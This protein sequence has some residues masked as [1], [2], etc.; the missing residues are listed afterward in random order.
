MRL[1]AL[2]VRGFKS[3]ADAAL[4]PLD[5]SLIGVVGPNGSGKSNIAD[6]LRWILGEQK[7]RLLRAEKSE[8]LIFNGS[9]QRR[10]LPFAEVS[11]EV[12]GFS[13][14]LPRLTFLRRIHRSGESEYFLN[15]APVRLKDFLAHFWEIGLSPQSIL[16]GGQVE[17]LIHDRG[18][19]RRA[20]IESLAG[21]ER[22][23]FQ[24]KEA[25]VQLERTTQALEQLERV[26]AELKGQ[27]GRLRSQAEKVRQY[28]QLRER[29]QQ[30]LSQ[31]I[32]WQVAQIEKQA[33]RLRGQR[34]ELQQQWERLEQEIRGL[35]LRIQA[36][37]E[38][39][40]T[41]ELTQ[42][43]AALH[44]LRQGLHGVDKE[45]GLLQERLVHLQKEA[46]E[47]EEERAYRVR[48]AEELLQEEQRLRE[49]IE[50][51][52]Q[53]HFRAQEALHSLHPAQQSLS[54]SI[55]QAEKC[56]HELRTRFQEVEK[57]KLTMQ[58]RLHSLQASIQSVRE[59]EAEIDAAI[60]S[61]Q[62]REASWQEERTT[63]EAELRALEAEFQ[64]LQ[65]ALQ[66]RLNTE[67]LLS[68]QKQQLQK[69]LQQVQGR[70]EGVLSRKR[71]LQSIFQRGEALPA[72][73]AKLRQEGAPFWTTEEIFWAD[74]ATLPLLGVLLR[75]L[76][77]TIWITSEE[78]AQ[79][80][81]PLILQQKEGFFAMRVYARNAK[82]IGESLELRELEEFEGLGGYLW[83]GVD[84]TCFDGRAVKLKDG[85]LYQLS[86]VRTEHI[87]I[88][89]R[90]KGLEQEESQLRAVAQEVQAQLGDVERRLESLDLQGLRR[91]CTAKE[92]EIMHCQQRLSALQARYE[93]SQRSFRALSEEHMRLTQRLTS[94]EEEQAKFQSEL[95][96]LEKD[97]LQVKAQEAQKQAELA[98]LQKVFQQQQKNYQAQYV[99]LI[100]IEHDLQASE[101]THRLILKQLE[102]VRSRQHALRDRQTHLSEDLE[103]VQQRL[104]EL[105][106]HKSRIEPEYQRLQVQYQELRQA[107]QAR[108]RLLRQLH[109]ELSRK[110][111]Q[112]DQLHQ[113]IAT[114]E[115]QNHSLAQQKALLLQRLSVELEMRPEEL[116]PE[117]TLSM[118]A[119]QV[120]SHLGQIK[121]KIAQLGEINFEAERALAELEERL[122]HLLREK[123]EI[124]Q[125][126]EQLSTL[127]K[128]VEKEA[129][130]R[131]MEAFE[132]VRKAF[133]NLFQRLFQEGD[134]CDVV[135][136][137][138]SSP[139]TSEIE[140]IARPR[141]KKLLSLQQLSGGE[142]ALTALALLFSVFSVRPSIF[143]VLD[144]VDAPLDDVNAHR[145]G[146][147]LREL[148]Q[149][150][151]FL[152]ITHNKITMAYCERL[153][154]VS[155]PEPGVST[156][157]GVEMAKVAA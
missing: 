5:A 113:Q 44:S 137:D 140:I 135:L 116:P 114:C 95:A 49:K 75:S 131:F 145:F 21:I 106:A 25:T 88:P 29:Y 101:K 83:S 84:H 74:E 117:G 50:A 51:L 85:W 118:P 110:Q 1:K 78:V 14:D 22:Y 46:R 6:A 139:L 13:P 105:Q 123:Q 42:V 48:Q 17:A 8:N 133:S 62:Q 43:E 54:E 10:P 103:K 76:P 47:K 143:C 70:I 115:S 19:A 91:L 124:E 72:F 104:T 60:A 94:L 89:H 65:T 37:E 125:V 108:E 3:F 12:E 79:T 40:Q 92:R 56:L 149:H 90:L 102:E 67:Q 20:L 35:E 59:R 41:Q 150:V 58:A 69:Q 9:P 28:R 73:L 64:R 30:L 157:L 55:A 109:Q 38:A 71:A 130:H 11:L 136:L 63:L 129:K 134:T 86:P 26:L 144:E 155:M 15:G 57:K 147:L 39:Q 119:E 77:P 127:L 146:R 81:H 112:K 2:Q 153:Y 18:G 7:G 97:W 4:I 138:P 107:Y 128:Q 121:E 100:Q 126:W 68:A 156:L 52:R 45:A 61:A 36:A 33:E 34:V 120:E 82:G 141:G 23:H 99:Q 154:G 148:A 87:G 53:T 142:K 66:E 98:E 152:V 93:E 122:S 111:Q 96:S 27:I 16:D 151:T 132:A 32:A 31:W 24:K 80:L